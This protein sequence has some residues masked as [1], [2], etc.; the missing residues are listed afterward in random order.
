MNIGNY[1][2]IKNT[3]KKEFN[4]NKEKINVLNDK[5]GILEKRK[6]H[7]KS[8]S[9]IAS[10]I[11]SFMV[12]FG[13]TIA[14]ASAGFPFFIAYCIYMLTTV[15]VVTTTTFAINFMKDLFLKKRLKSFSKSKNTLERFIEENKYICEKGNIFHQNEAIK[16]TLDKLDKH[17][18][19]PLNPIQNIN[20]NDNIKY[21]EMVI[22]D[23]K[24][25]SIAK[26][27]LCDEINKIFK[28]YYAYASTPMNKDKFDRIGYV[29]LNFFSFLAVNCL[30][31]I[32]FCLNSYV[33]SINLMLLITF[34]S[35]MIMTIAY[36]ALKQIYEKRKEEVLSKLNSETITQKNNSFSLQN[37]LRQ[38]L[39][40]KIE[41]LSNVLLQLE[42]KKMLLGNDELELRRT[43]SDNTKINAKHLKKINVLSYQHMN[44]PNDI[45]EVKD[46]GF[47]L[48]KKRS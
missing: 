18:E 16:K 36:N 23:V 46:K 14:L 45:A 21:K 48:V 11:L 31:C 10:N 29:I 41:D 40:R 8:F 20:L 42:Q 4:I 17:S 13:T 3:L 26:K 1:E 15:G 5:I 7:K 22:Q 2:E 6:I 37:S 34:G 24:N 28:K 27:N 47:Q 38:D 39:N 44:I 30:P 9:F 32:A 35:S 33:T 12:G 43:F 19:N 25:L